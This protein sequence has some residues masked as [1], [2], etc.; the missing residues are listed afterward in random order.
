MSSN[1][2]EA[3]FMR[4][5]VQNFEIEGFEPNEKLRSEVDGIFIQPTA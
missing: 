2:Y 4:E 5:A 1:S 3:E